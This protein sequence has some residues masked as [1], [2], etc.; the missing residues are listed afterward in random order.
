MNKLRPIR[1][2]DI[3][4]QI[5]DWLKLKRW[6]HWRQNS[7]AMGGEYQSKRTGKNKKWYV[8][9]GRKGIPDIFV[10]RSGVCWGIEVKLPGKDQSREQYEFQVEFE[11]SGGRYI[12]AFSLDDAIRAMGMEDA[13]ECASRSNVPGLAH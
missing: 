8:R 11:R 5:L 2:H 6:M 1:E 13:Y 10:I 4:S 12:L 3:Q 7:G 9:F